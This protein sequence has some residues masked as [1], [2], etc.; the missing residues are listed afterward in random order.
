M[1]IIPSNR[2]TVKVNFR[3]GL[4]LEVTPAE[5][6]IGT[7]QLILNLFIIKEILKRMGVWHPIRCYSLL[8]IWYWRL[9][10]GYWVLGMGYGLFGIRNS[11]VQL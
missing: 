7:F 9:G 5:Y 6:I 8:V 10:F 2:S 11:I 3:T 4:A 1:G